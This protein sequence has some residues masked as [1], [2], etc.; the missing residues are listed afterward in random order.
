MKVLG[1]L[2]SPRKGGNTD[3]LLE[4]ALEGAG[5]SGAETEK[6]VLNDLDIAPCQEREYENINEE[7]LSVVED[8]IQLIFRAIKEA[9]A[10]IVASPV[11]FGSLSAQTK[12]MIDRFQCVWLAKNILHRDVFGKRMKG[13]FICVEASEREDFFDNARSIVRHFFATIN[14]SY[15]EELFSPGVEKKGDVLEKSDVLR[16]AY[17]MGKA[18]AGSD[19]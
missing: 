16:K 10:L 12:T 15:E 8:D 1:L 19:R 13:G 14:I 5:S 4:K 18:L 11:F 3:V 7:G 17:D 2:G 9:D 6:L